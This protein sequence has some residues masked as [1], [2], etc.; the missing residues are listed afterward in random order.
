MAAHVNRVTVHL[1]VSGS[2]GDP[3]GNASEFTAWVSHPIQIRPAHSKRNCCEAG[4]LV[5]ARN[6]MLGF[7]PA[8]QA[9]GQETYFMHAGIEAIYDDVPVPVGL[10]QFAPA[11]KASGRNVF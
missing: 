10:A 11:K 6:L 7:F 2:G 9:S 5:V 3:F 1:S 4:R 8:A